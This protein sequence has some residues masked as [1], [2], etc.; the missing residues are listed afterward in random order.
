MRGL[1]QVL[2]IAVSAALALGASAL[3]AKPAPA[4]K[5]YPDVI[6]L[7][8]GWQPEGI[9]VGKGTSFYVGSLA[10]GSVYRGDLRT[11]KGAQLVAP[12]GRPA[13]GLEVDNRGR[14][15]VAGGPSGIGSV[16]GASG[17][18]LK[19]YTLAA[20]GAFVNDVVV[21]TKAAWFT[22]SQ[23]SQLYR[24]AI[25]AGGALAAAATTVKL[26]GDYA[27]G[28]GFNVNGI[29]ATPDGKWLVIVQTGSGRLYRVDA[30][31]G[32][33]KAIA[34]EGGATVPGGD[35][36][37]LAGKTLFVVQNRM[38]KVAVIELAPDLLRG[39][40]TNTITDPDLDVPTTIARHGAVLYAVNAR[41]GTPDPGNAAYSVVKLVR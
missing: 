39:A 19:T 33:T 32:A 17:A 20:S 26:T 30:A 9:A 12:Q 28:P 11:G 24:V 13:V 22:D 21:T 5:P 6:A 4:A 34:L 38:N 18:P 31:T 7:P 1:V 25:G 10:T 36:I 15:W 8:K 14:I 16:F 37:L 23:Q 3:A 41:F 27:P 40:V 2:V 29:D 35:G